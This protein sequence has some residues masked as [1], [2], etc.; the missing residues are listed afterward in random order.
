VPRPALTPADALTYLSALSADLRAAVLLDS[1]GSVAACSDEPRA[2]RLRELVLELLRHA[3][4]H[5]EEPPAQVEVSASAGA[6]FAT[7]ERGW[8]LAVVTGRLTLPSLMF[9]DMHNVLEA[10]EVRAA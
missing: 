7:R 9:Y 5:A 4:S 1:D 6:V 8:T 2:E 10:L 3:D